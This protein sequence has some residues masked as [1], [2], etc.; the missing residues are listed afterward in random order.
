MDY[1]NKC[2]SRAKKLSRGL[3]GLHKE[4]PTKSVKINKSLDQ[5]TGTFM[6]KK[7]L[8]SGGILL[9]LAGFIVCGAFIGIILFAKIKPVQVAQPVNLMPVDAAALPVSEN[10]TV[11]SVDLDQELNQL[12]QD[13]IGV[14]QLMP[15]ETI[16]RNTLSPDELRER[17]VNDF[18]ADYTEDDI[19]R[20]TLLYALLGVIE[21]DFDLYGFIIDLYSEQIAGFYDDET[22]EMVV[23]QGGDFGGPERMTYAHEFTHLLQDQN[24]DFENGLKLNDELLD[25]NM[26]RYAAI[27]S[28]VEGDA[29][30][31]EYLWYQDFA[32][33]ADNMDVQQFSMEMVTPIY[34]QAPPFIQNELLFPYQF[35]LDFVHSVY[36]AQGWE[37]VAALYENPPQSTEQILHPER[38]PDDLPIT[39]TLEDNTSLLP[40][41]WRKLHES[42]MG[43]EYLYLLLNGGV[44][45]GYTDVSTVWEAVKGW[46]GDRY[47]LYIHDDSGAVVFVLKIV[48]DSEQ[49]AEEFSAAFQAYAANRWPEGSATGADQFSAMDAHFE[50]VS[51]SRKGAETTWMFT[52]DETTT[53][54]LRDSLGL[55]VE[56]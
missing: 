12:Q 28:L 40:F 37:G 7:L 25:E 31:S 55:K 16:Y 32:T 22:K 17:V 8:L 5:G 10:L 13:V 29:V 56:Q 33:D 26:D 35:G 48:W 14:R 30:M 2:S 1:N 47:Q 51:F 43:E 50:Q 9:L 19:Q 36:S 4:F 39:V 6:G 11:F 38:Y 53:S 24:Y 41:G 46:G 21:P 20:D 44:K 42:T 27:Q 45:D 52:P 54:L 23:V 18:F 3:D 15:D 49:D 34:D